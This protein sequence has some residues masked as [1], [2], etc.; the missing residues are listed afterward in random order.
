MDVVALHTYLG[1]L[2]APLP[3][4]ADD[5]N[6]P[7]AVRD[8]LT[9]V[10][11]NRLTVG[12]DGA[13][14]SSDGTVL[15]VS[16][17]CL[18]PDPWPVAGL[19][20]ATVVPGTATLRCTAD[21]QVTCSVEG[22][23]ALTAT[24]SA[25]VTVTSQ[26]PVMTIDDAPARPWLI[27]LTADVTGV[28]PLDL[29][30]LG[31][32]GGAGA[33]AR[34][35]TEPPGLDAV[36]RS[37]LLPAS[38]FGVTCYPN[39]AFAASLTFEVDVPGIAWT[40]VPGLFTL[41]QVGLRAMV[42]GT[43]WAAAVIGRF[44]IGGVPM[45]VSVG[46][47]DAAVLTAV[48]KPVG[49]PTFPGL[50]ALAAWLGGAAIAPAA[51]SGSSSGSGSGSSTG[52][53]SDQGD[54]QQ[55][56]PAPG[57]GPGTG[58]DVAVIG[59][60][61]AKADLAISSLTVRF[62]AQT[63]TLRRAEVV[64]ELVLG[65]LRLDVAVRY[66]EGA[67]VGGLHNGEPL[68]LAAVLAS[69]GLPEA[70]L[71]A[72]TR[73]TQAD[74]SA[75]PAFGFYSA[76]LTVDTGLTAGPLSID[77]VFVSVSRNPRDGVT[78]QLGGTV[79][80]E[81]GLQVELLADHGGAAV[82]WEFS[83]RTAPGT[84][85]HIGGLLD[86][87]A[88]AFGATDVP[89]PVTQLALTDIAVDYQ[90]GTGAFAF[91]CTGTLPVADTPVSATVGIAVTPL[92]SGGYEKVF[93]GHLAIGDLDFDLVFDTADTG[94]DIFV[95]AYSHTGDAQTL[96]LHDL[97]AQVS[98]TAAQLVPSGLDIG[99]QDARLLY[100][101][102]ATGDSVFALSLVLSAAVDLSQLPLIGDKLPPDE[103]LAV[104]GLQ[105]CYSS[106]D[107]TAEQLT[108]VGALL[109]GT[110]TPL[111]AGPL[112]TGVSISARLQAGPDQR[113]T[114]LSLPATAPAASTA[115][116]SSGTGTSP[117]TP[118][119]AAPAGY[120]LD[121]QRQLGV[122]QIN[123]I[124]LLYQDGALFVGLD[125]DVTLGPLSLSLDGLCFGSPL[126]H[127]EPEFR[128]AGLG[129]AYASGPLT[130][131]GALLRVPED[132]LAP[133][134]SFQFDGTVR[135]KAEQLAIA[136]IGSYAQFADGRPSLFVFAELAAPLGGPP[137]FFVD[138]LA[139]G[140]GFNRTLALPGPD[141]VTAFP[142]VALGAPAAPGQPAAG[143]DPSHVLDVLEGRAPLTSAG[144]ARPWITP[145]PGALWL[146]FGAAFTSYELV[147]T[148]ALL[149][150]DISDRFKL[151]VLGSSVLRLPQA[152]DSPRAYA[153]VE[154]GIEAVLEPED[155]H[156]GLTAVLSRASYVI[157][158]ECHLTGGFAVAA[159]FGDH[160][161]AGE[162]VLTLGGYH[163]AFAVPGHFPAVP[164]LGFS[165][166]VSDTVSISGSAYAALTTSCFMAGGRLEALFQDG[167]LR[168]W[169]IVEAD[170]LVS[171]RPFFFTGHFALSIGVSYTFSALGIQNTISVSVGAGLDLWGPPT[172]GSVHVELWVVSFT[173]AFGAPRDPA[174]DAPL[175][176]TQ[177][178]DLLPP[179]AS[180]VVVQPGGE[181]RDT[182]SDRRTWVVRATGFS[183]RTQSA[184]P[185]S[186][187]RYG[188]PT[189][190]AAPR[191]PAPVAPAPVTAAPTAPAPAASRTP[192]PVAT[193]G[194]TGIAA[195]AS[196]ASPHDYTAAPIDIK[197]MN[198]AGVSSVH[199]LTIRFGSSSGPALD[200]SGWTLTPRTAAVADALWGKPEA[201]FSQ[202]PARPA[203]EVLTGRYVGYDVQTPAPKLGASHGTVPAAAL[204]ADYIARAAMPLR[205][206]TP[207]GRYR[208]GPDRNSVDAISRL[209]VSAVPRARLHDALAALTGFTGPNG[210]LDR[211]AAA[212][213]HLYSDAPMRE[214]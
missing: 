113:H 100:L 158:P 167:G 121:V 191:S 147:H 160:P 162:F 80:F 96:S 127:F 19:G 187:L 128:L 185:V 88:K 25:P 161:H 163:P 143:S 209:A 104:D 153:Y 140:F 1:T 109:P 34:A 122:V 64:T 97:V 200:V 33:M 63:A 110:A 5:Q 199:R 112:T 192:Q 102:P 138:G 196:P 9:G 60:D 22:R 77:E 90:T 119:A 183:F 186:G 13:G 86:D 89:R 174:S 87:L 28:T 111:P 46:L 29:L 41:D 171:W 197:P 180:R 164:R 156:F 67:V 144:T 114:A 66:P 23:L 42:S 76:D 92:A 210:S 99:L 12:A 106:A 52:S 79:G 16:G 188:P 45:E 202:I 145:H 68:E 118:A 142:L 154:L 14:L 150:A 39:T 11:G 141:E 8:F 212:A 165:W 205:P 40:P 178:R 62:D 61:R 44:G 4:A 70:G 72:A 107:L 58:A 3:L 173:V 137:A 18:G 7:A 123:R 6:L 37:L 157:A 206:G 51:G 204:A 201:Q 15:T 120:W 98:P 179:A 213:G 176:W 207:P 75:V 83:G 74:F 24:V 84:E 131:S 116:G 30:A 193:G 177:F 108:Q 59:G 81:S 49:S 85:L 55:L 101:K 184:L 169:F 130:L 152:A 103:T 35:V 82:G 124:G 31:R 43:G 211:L 214:G 17:P 126:S 135:I 69:F 105:I 134:I 36:A 203:A 132:H 170:L 155:G 26:P 56:V 125:A 38:G 78:G 139:A 48:L 95:A 175:G 32:P 159:W 146:A 182:L 50:A 94:S 151:A 93:S 190:P 129:L 10:P 195:S 166:A 181:V 208:P 73:I 54:D 117:A 65:E 21:D 194:G 189:A 53:G 172:G 148:R 168:A 198:L 115:S 133:G 91:T 20:T 136:G 71:P 47:S 57:S 27:S 149:V 2:G